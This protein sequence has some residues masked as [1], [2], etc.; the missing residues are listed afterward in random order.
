MFEYIIIGFLGILLLLVF[1]IYQK[2]NSKNDLGVERTVNEKLGDL[3]TKLQTI[4]D[5]KEKIESLQRDMLDFNNLFSNKTDR[6]KFGEEYLEDIVKDSINKKHQISTY[7]SNA[8][9]PTAS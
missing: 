6:G 5:T 9:D 3:N 2:T 8:K 4:A 7:T 1:L